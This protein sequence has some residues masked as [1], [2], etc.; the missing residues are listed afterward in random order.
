MLEPNFASQARGK[1]PL[2]KEA[3]NKA[4]NNGH[5]GMPEP[6]FTDEKAPPIFFL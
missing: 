3:L 2:P 5:H 6:N 4:T 1:I